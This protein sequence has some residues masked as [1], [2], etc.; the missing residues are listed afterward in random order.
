MVKFAIWKK[1]TANIENDVNLDIVT[2]NA[3]KSTTGFDGD[4]KGGPGSGGAATGYL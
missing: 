4:E 3:T 1:T 2:L